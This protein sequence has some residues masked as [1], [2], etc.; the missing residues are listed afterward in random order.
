MSQS[1]IDLDSEGRR[2]NVVTIGGGTGS[3][4]L[5]KGLMHYSERINISAIVTTFDDGGSTGRLREEFGVPALGDL[6]RCIAALLPTDDDGATIE[7]LF[8]HR[9]TSEG[10]LN[11]H[12][13]GNLI[14]LGAWQ[15]TD[16]LTQAIDEIS[17]SLHLLGQVIPVSDQPTDVCANLSDGTVIR[18]ESA[19]GDRNEELFGAGEIYLDPPVE[20]NPDALR[21]IASANV[22][23][24]GPGDLF[25]SVIPNLLVNGM[26]EA[27]RESSAKIL[28]ICNLATKQGESGSYAASDFALAIN[29]ILKSDTQ[30]GIGSKRVDAIIVN[31]F[32]N[33]PPDGA[34]KID[35]RLGEVVG[36]VITR[37]VADTSN[38]CNHDPLKLASAVMEY[39]EKVTTDDCR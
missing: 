14:L 16:S 6:R 18:G 21:A 31:D 34:I 12:S 38:P 27:L 37:P 13:L 26:I 17:N 5:L 1:E 11:D 10:E 20:A 4:T 7:R 15:R 2:I 33:P 29:R 9:F 22:V 36:T 30:R 23:I 32:E 25:T 28:Q 19:V 24:L 3:S 35:E 39:V 8:E